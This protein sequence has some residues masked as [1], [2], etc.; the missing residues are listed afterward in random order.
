MSWRVVPAA[1]TLRDQVN[2]RWP[3]RDK[4]SDGT[5][6]DAEHQGRP[7]DH[8]PDADGWVHALDLDADL[9]EPAAMHADRKSVV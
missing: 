4:A 3:D 2:A 5:I 8:N 1:L 6:G 7:S 9:G